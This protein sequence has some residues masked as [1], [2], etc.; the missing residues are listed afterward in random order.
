MC[1][2]QDRYCVDFNNAEAQNIEYTGPSSVDMTAE[3][4]INRPNGNDP[5]FKILSC[6][7]RPA[8]GAREPDS[9]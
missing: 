9:L 7:V 5:L 8:H 3:Q 1:L 2:F 6:A 4:N